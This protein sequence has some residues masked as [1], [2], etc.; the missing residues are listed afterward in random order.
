[1][2]QLTIYVKDIVHGTSLTMDLTTTI[3]IGRLHKKE[4][5]K[6]PTIEHILRR[7]GELLFYDPTI[8]HFHGEISYTSNIVSYKDNSKNGTV[9]FDTQRQYRLHYRS[10]ILTPNTTLF[11]G[12]YSAGIIGNHF[13]LHLLEN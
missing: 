11:L 8:S 1:M 13:S 6:N 7:E 4:F 10:I 12:G 3:R 2:S 9:Y 5:T